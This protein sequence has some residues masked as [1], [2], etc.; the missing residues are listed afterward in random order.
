[1]QEGIDFVIAWVDGTDPAWR[2]RK[3]S[4]EPKG[5]EG[6]KE[7]SSARYRD[8][9]LLRYWFRAVEK[10]APWVRKIWF[11]TEGHLPAWLDTNNPRISVVRHEDYIPEEY[12]PTFSSH[13][14]E[15]NLFRIR[16]LSER[17][18]YF[19]DDMYLMRQV[20]EEDFF[21]NGLPVDEP[22]L[23][24][25]CPLKGKIIHNISL[26]DAGVINDHFDMRKIM[27]RDRR[28]WFNPKIGIKHLTLNLAL[29][30]CPRF[31]GFHQFHAPTPM[32]RSVCEEAWEKDSSLAETS[33]RRI[34]DI[35]DLNQWI[36]R[37]WAIAEGKYSVGA[38][39]KQNR[40]IAFDQQS[41]DEAM[42]ELQEAFDDPRLKTLC[43]NDYDHG[44]DDFDVERVSRRI[45]EMFEIKLSEKSSFEKDIDGDEAGKNA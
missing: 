25:H 36:F 22:A 9:N 11:V 18:V 27:R 32:L 34:R 1:M 31:P 21:R 35:R 10:Y 15:L 37:E 26:N 3:K 6:G 5:A 13:P 19:N 30:A 8:W 2:Q 17:F 45:A 24:I 33:A 43:I 4:Y 38:I 7:D 39:H 41:L 40:M 29:S 14:I 16:G 44:G 20:R 23:W 42:R 28:K 12:L